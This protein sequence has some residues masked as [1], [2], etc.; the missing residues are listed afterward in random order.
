MG[1]VK[2]DTS[3]RQVAYDQAFNLGKPEG[4]LNFLRHYHHLWA[5]RNEGDIEAAVLFLDFHK[6]WEAESQ[7]NEWGP[8]TRREREVIHLLYGLGLTKKEVA[9]KLGI[10]V[11]NVRKHEE[12]A[13][14]KL[15]YLIGGP[16]GTYSE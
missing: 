15:A 10:S 4:I 6:A 13:A 14:R 12:K 7:G 1:M 3:K 9:K 11:K 5:R 16:N 8:L 2:I